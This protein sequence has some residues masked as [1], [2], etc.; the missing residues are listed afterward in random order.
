MSVYVSLGAAWETWDT[1]YSGDSHLSR[2]VLGG[3]VE[4]PDELAKS[5]ILS[6]ASLM[7]KDL[8]DKLGFTTAEVKAH[9]T[10]KMHDS[11]PDEFLKKHDAMRV[12]W[13]GYR[14]QLAQ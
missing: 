14:A 6:G 8:F 7:P 11:A 2:L 5:A 3:E 9:P 12:A 1:P 10:T 13:Q 4:M